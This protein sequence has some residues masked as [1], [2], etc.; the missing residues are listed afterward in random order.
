M[1]RKQLR[2]AA[3]LSV[4]LLT[5][6]NTFIRVAGPG[7]ETSTGYVIEYLK[8]HSVVASTV[9]LTSLVLFVFIVQWLYFVVR[10]L[11]VPG[12]GQFWRL[13]SRNP[14]AAYDWFLHSPDW[15]VFKYP[16]PLGFRDV[17]PESEWA[18]PFDLYVP[19]IHSR[20][21]IFG[22]VGKYESARIGFIDL[23]KNS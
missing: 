21:Q 10:G 23:I 4:V 12:V 19:A 15:K 9:G 8:T 3:I 6:A 2:N 18:G 20:V 7:D 17:V 16:P 11:R 13:V 1:V 14:D 5:I 22:R